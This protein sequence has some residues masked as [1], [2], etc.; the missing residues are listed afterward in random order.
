MS[1][2][3]MFATIGIIATSITTT[4]VV[5][6]KIVAL[7]VAIARLQVQVSHYDERIAKLEKA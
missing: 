3:I 4:V 2:E 5:Y 7:E 1:I 6:S